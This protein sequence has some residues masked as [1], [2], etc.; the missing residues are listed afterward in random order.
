MVDA[1]PGSVLGL[2]PGSQ[3]PTFDSR[4]AAEAKLSIFT[5]FTWQYD[6]APSLDCLHG[7]PGRCSIGQFP[8]FPIRRA[9]QMRSVDL[10]TSQ[11]ARDF[12]GVFDHL[13]QHRLGW[14]PRG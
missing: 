4:I 2:A 9:A 14:L 6:E 7:L 10:G 12:S 8:H 3:L 5:P 13:N 1:V 11:F